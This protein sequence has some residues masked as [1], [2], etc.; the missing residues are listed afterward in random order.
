[1]FILFLYWSMLYICWNVRFLLTI[2]AI[3]PLVNPLYYML[4]LNSKVSCSSDCKLITNVTADF[5]DLFASDALKSLLPETQ[6]LLNNNV[7][8]YQRRANTDFCVRSKFNLLTFHFTLMWYTFCVSGIDWPVRLDW[9][10]AINM[11]TTYTLYRHVTQPK[12]RVLVAS[13]SH[14]P[15]Y[16]SFSV[17]MC[18]F[19]IL[20]N[21]YFSYPSLRLLLHFFVTVCYID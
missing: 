15:L 14:L 9:V 8:S 19:I 5:V 20:Y 13:V 2:T 21:L 10:D 17:F 1:M 7:H 3:Q 12:I 18:I 4:E 6:L 11:V 16:L